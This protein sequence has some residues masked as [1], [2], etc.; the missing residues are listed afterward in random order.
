VAE[1][2]IKAI[3]TSYAG[4]HFRSRL[5]A[6]WAVFFDALKIPWQYEAQGYVVGGRPYLPDFDLPNPDDGKS[7]LVEVKGSADR[8]DASLIAATAL[9][10]DRAVLVLG[11]MPK[12]AVRPIPDFDRLARRADKESGYV[13]WTCYPDRGEVFWRETFWLAFRMTSDPDRPY[14]LPYPIGWDIT[15]APSA[16]RILGQSTWRV[17]TPQ[18]VWSAYRAGSTARFEHGETP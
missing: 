1:P 8:L 12:Q 11:P 15:K 4:C 16:D 9:E 13:H 14:W 7:Y 10:L 6:R 3:E 5:E 17:N 2:A 18:S